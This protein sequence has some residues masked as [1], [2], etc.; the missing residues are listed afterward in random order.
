MGGRRRRGEGSWE[1]ARK[2]WCSDSVEMTGRVHAPDRPNVVGP[3]ARP[4]WMSLLSWGVAPGYDVAGPSALPHTIGGPVNSIASRHD[5][6]FQSVGTYRI[7]SVS[8]F[9]WCHASTMRAPR[10]RRGVVWH[11]TG[12][13]VRVRL[14]VRGLF[15][16]IENRPSTA[17]PKFVSPRALRSLWFPDH[18]VWQYWQVSVVPRPCELSHPD[19]CGLP[20]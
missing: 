2:P 14:L 1:A 17:S 3:S 15:H 10:H 9:V 13:L 12:V 8:Q 6:A 18:W 20:P 5:C 4:H 11:A 19:G 16:T 7:G